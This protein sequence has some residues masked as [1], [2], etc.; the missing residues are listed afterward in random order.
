[1]ILQTER[2]IIRPWRHEDRAHYAAFNADPVVRRFYRT[3]LTPQETEAVID[4][5]IAGF[6]TDGYGFLA[7]ER[8]SDGAFIGDVGIAPMTFPLRGNTPVEIGWLLGQQYWGQGYAPEAAQAWIDHGLGTLGL[9]E[10]VAFTA[11]PNLPSQRVM[12]K[13]GMTRDPEGDFEHPGIPE[14]H[15]LR[16][17]LLYRI[18]NLAWSSRTA[19]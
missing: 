16:P 15:A 10:I 13:L 12:T 3:V 7:V 18:D 11:V 5:F 19:T 1:M 17:H 8:K 6:E 2:L 4:R 9:P 14:G